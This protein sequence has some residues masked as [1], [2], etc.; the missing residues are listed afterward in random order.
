MRFRCG[1]G[2]NLKEIL[3]LEGMIN[4]NRSLMEENRRLIEEIKELKADL[5]RYGM[6][7]LTDSASVTS[8]SGLALPATEKNAGIPGTIGSEI[9]KIKKALGD[10]KFKTV[11]I[12][13]DLNSG[14]Q[15]ILEFNPSDY[16]PEGS[17]VIACIESIP[18][19]WYGIYADRV[20]KTT[21][22]DNVFPWKYI[23]KSSES[24]G[25]S[26]FRI[27]VLIIYS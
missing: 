8:A 21:D 12:T 4:E 26:P 2:I 20:S 23:I 13:I 24:A 9:G 6:V 11:F 19:G 25:V 14:Q 22:A 1:G 3:R 10:Y 27:F 16:L 17:N 15:G 7:K 18:Q 5:T